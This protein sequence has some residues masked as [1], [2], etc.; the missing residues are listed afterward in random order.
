MESIYKSLIVEQ[1]DFTID[2]ITTN[3]IFVNNDATINGTLNVET[4][5]NTEIINV[6]DNQLVLNSNFTT[7]TPSL[8]SGIIV[9]RGDQD[10]ASILFNETSDQWEINGIQIID[11]TYADSNYSNLLLTDPSF[12]T[13]TTGRLDVD[14]IRLDGNTISTV[15]GNLE[16]NSLGDLSINDFVNFRR[17]I[18]T[19]NNVNN[20]LWEV[21]NI[22]ESHSIMNLL[23]SNGTIMTQLSAE[24]NGNSYI[25]GNLLLGSTTN[26][27]GR[28]LLVNGTTESTSILTD[29]LTSTTSS[30]GE[31]TCSKITGTGALT[32]F[33]PSGTDLYLRPLSGRVGINTT[34]PSTNLDVNG[35][36]QC[37]ANYYLKNSTS[38]FI[39]DVQTKAVG[40]YADIQLKKNNGTI[41]LFLSGLETNNSYIQ[42]NL[43]IGTS[44]NPSSR[45]LLVNGSIGATSL[46]VSGITDQRVI[47]CNNGSI[48]ATGLICSSST[49]N[50]SLPSN[51]LSVGNISLGT[52]TISTS[53]GALTLTSNTST[54][55][56]TNTLTVGDFTLS[57]N[58][59]SSSS[60]NT[61]MGRVRFAFDAAN[62]YRDL[63][64]TDPCQSGSSAF[65]G[66][67][68]LFP[69]ATIGYYIGTCTTD[70][71]GVA[72]D[73]LTGNDP[74]V[75][76]A[77]TTVSSR[78][79]LRT[80]GLFLNTASSNSDG[81]LGINCTN[82]VASAAL[83]V[84]STTKGFLMPRMDTT[85]RN[86]ISS[87][88]T[89]LQVYDTSL[90]S[91]CIYNGTNWFFPA[92]ITF[93]L[94]SDIQGPGVFQG[95]IKWDQ[96]ATSTGDN[97]IFNYSSLTGGFM[98]TQAGHYRV[99]VT[100]VFVNEDGSSGVER[101]VNF[102]L[103]TSTTVLCRAVAAVG[104]LDGD[105]TYDA[106]SI[107]TII[108]L[109]AN[110]IIRFF[111][112]SFNGGT[113]PIIMDNAS[114]G[115]IERIK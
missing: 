93:N 103:M 90:N 72:K 14:N 73:N 99:Q 50:F 52:N 42:S 38:N 77:Y 3:N 89:G 114:H 41:N 36:I 30:L 43:L 34:S 75:I 1:E 78:E 37:N 49:G 16:I 28:K 9:K 74:D 23:Q 100:A 19:R 61:N 8:D 46:Y 53:S 86:T 113:Y 54:V 48:E 4:I 10:D 60:V 63:S 13:T 105:N 35:S 55:N 83:Q 62:T 84:D 82:T 109:T 11:K 108:Y 33:T 18:M 31:I 107:N 98:V 69:S 24:S 65:Y 96:T 57:G 2:E 15:S 88:A 45:K 17:N 85:A 110:Q 94:T 58:T 12:T 79:A 76:M 91:V 92:W 102:D 87:P 106:C 32:I 64:I 67:I 40:D 27:N 101:A 7:G 39:F 66:R 111:F 80:T 95:D 5:L 59:I 71:F 21:L 25:T 44:S 20:K 29:S 47:Y 104:Y 97:S 6:E 115:Y 22:S 51:T 112:Q 26:T 70:G 56:V 81:V 68:S